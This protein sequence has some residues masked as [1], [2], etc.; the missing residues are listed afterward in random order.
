MYRI[1]NRVVLEIV[2]RFMK[3]QVK[4]SSSHERDARYVA[5]RMNSG[6]SM[7]AFWFVTQCGLTDKYRRFEGTYCFDLKFTDVRMSSHINGHIISVHLKRVQK[8]SSIVKVC[9]LSPI[10]L[11]TGSEPNINIPSGI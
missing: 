4:W 6:M 3:L 10:G 1:G 8:A 5:K 11:K 7:L 2:F 9:E